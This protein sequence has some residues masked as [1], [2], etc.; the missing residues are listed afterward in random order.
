MKKVSVIIPFY[1]HVDWLT[2]ALESVL[3]QTYNN[4]EIIVV[5]DG[6]PE[7]M[8][9]FLE[10]YGSSII[11]LYQENSGP[12]SARNNGIKHSSGDYIAFED[13][14]DIWLPHKL[15]YQISFME[16]MSLMWSHTG[17]YNW[18][19]ASDKVT[20]G[21]TDEVYG[22]ILT[23]KRVS[24]GIATP[25]IV[26][27]RKVFVA[28]GLYFPE[29]L[30]IGEDDQLYT[31]LARRYPIGL[32]AEPLVKVRMR[33]TNSYTLAIPRFKLRAK[34]YYDWKKRGEK[35]PFMIHLIHTIYTFYARIFRS[36]NNKVAEFVAKIFW[37][38]PYSI[39]RIY[40]LFLRLNKNQEDADYKMKLSSVS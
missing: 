16:K 12:A 14:D 4:I 39:E 13:S 37:T 32:V 26:I 33:N 8:T 36:S 5:N 18:W 25:S 15:Q 34:N 31:E 20:L 7:D 24:A 11:Y 30:R 22:D 40:L 28:D 23:Q 2:E 3:A 19:P 6:S 35:F 10:R 21:K 9:D 29:A 27:D 1:R 38:L 17:Y